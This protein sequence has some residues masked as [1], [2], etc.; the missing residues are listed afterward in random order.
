[1]EGQDFNLKD[2]LCTD[3][4]ELGWYDIDIEL[5]TKDLRP[6]ERPEVQR[7][8]NDCPVQVECLEEGMA[9]KA[10]DKRH[11]GIHA[12]IRPDQMKNLMN[13]ENVAKLESVKANLSRR[14]DEVRR[15]MQMELIGF[16]AALIDTSQKA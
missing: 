11:T 4:N 13:L 1:M 2:G 9:I 5:F 6:R 16:M 7:I 15:K 10:T 3:T 12:G 14:Q 8:C